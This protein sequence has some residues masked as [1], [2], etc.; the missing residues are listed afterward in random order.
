MVSALSLICE[1]TLKAETPALYSISGK[2][3]DAKTSETI[4]GVGINLKDTGIWT[5]T[6][7]DGRFTIQNIPQGSCSLVFACL[8]YTDRTLDFKLS[9]NIESLTIKLEPNTLALKTVVVTA[10]RDK[11]GLNSSLQ[12][13]SNALET[14][15]SRTSQ[16]SGRCFREA[17][18][19]IRTSRK[20]PL[21]RFETAGS[22]PGT[23]HSEPQWKWT[24]C[25]SGTMH[26]SEI[27]PAQ[28][29]E[30]CRPRT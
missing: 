2:V 30:T 29:P 7:E 24:E 1:V 18:P 28:A 25:E 5:V 27:C 15:K 3:I 8:G 20:T 6:D 13:S 23:Q 22:I 10:Q 14:S 12:F 4:V 11:D 19:L 21:Y 9:R 16:T 17:R 26:H